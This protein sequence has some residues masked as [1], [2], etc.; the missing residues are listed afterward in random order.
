MFGLTKNRS[1]P[2]RRLRLT[3]L[4]I[5]DPRA[6]LSTGLVGG[7]PEAASQP[8][9]L[10]QAGLAAD[11]TAPSEVDGLRT[12]DGILFPADFIGP[13]Q[14]GTYR[15][16]FVA[17][18][19]PASVEGAATESPED[20]NNLG[21]PGFKGAPGGTDLNSGNGSTPAAGAPGANPPGQGQDDPTQDAQDEPEG[22]HFTIE[23]SS[24]G[25]LEV[26][27]V[28]GV[29]D[30][31]AGEEDPG[32]E[33]IEGAIDTVVKPPPIMGIPADQVPAGGTLSPDKLEEIKPDFKPEGEY[34]GPRG[35]PGYCPEGVYV[36][37]PGYY[38]GPN[39]NW[40]YAGG[41]ITFFPPSDGY[42]QD[43]TYEHGAIAIIGPVYVPGSGP[44]TGTWVLLPPL[45]GHYAAGDGRL[46]EL[47]ES[48]PGA[49]PGNPSP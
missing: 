13:L 9:D 39:G 15:G 46:I 8:T 44:D 47:E 16:R 19:K 42:P 12:G 26:E 5:L 17:L 4:E 38:Q 36:Y 11:R 22:P 1:T 35:N 32:G 31:G 25:K 30:E 28:I 33:Q 34:P 48:L 23:I 18:T 20:F 14:E 24:D 43:T 49:A 27:I 21:V 37:K 45:D 10:T 7:L 3:G 29:T 41:G 6:L 40:F 2:H